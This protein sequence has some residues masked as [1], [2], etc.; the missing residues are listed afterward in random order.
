MKQLLCLFMI[1]FSI[2]CHAQDLIVKTNGE[3]IKAKV[4]AVSEKDIEYKKENNPDGPLYKII[5]SEVL[6]IVYSTG[7]KEMF[8]TSSAVNANAATNSVTNN[9][10]EYAMVVLN[11]GTNDITVFIKNEEKNKYSINDNTIFPTIAN[12]LKELGDQG[13]QMESSNYYLVTHWGGK[14]GVA[15]PN[16]TVIYL[17]R[18]V[19]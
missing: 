7:Q 3:E 9:K 11:S 13:W 1:I 10:V 17:S 19:K 4:K 14:M 6:M 8:T 5:K 12:I 15:P 2:V 18:Q 16:G